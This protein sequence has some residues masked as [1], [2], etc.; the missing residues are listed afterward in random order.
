MKK[1]L[2]L[3][4]V[5]L[6]F[7]VIADDE[8]IML[9][10]FERETAEAEDDMSSADTTLNGFGARLFSFKNEGIYLGA[11]FSYL[12]GD[13]EYCVGTNCVSADATGTSFFGEIGRGMGHWTP[14]VGLSFTSSEV[15][16]MGESDSEETWGLSAGLWLQVDTFLLRGAVLNLDD[17]D[18]RAISGGVLF[19]VSTNFTL[20]GEFGMNLD[21]EVDGFKLSLQIGRKF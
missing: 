19:P 14:F 21:S 16:L 3:P 12:T 8:R 10:S 6:A 1:L 17:E 11:G 13:S 18:N 7:C 15:D 4:L 2:V 20:G 9:G 5:L